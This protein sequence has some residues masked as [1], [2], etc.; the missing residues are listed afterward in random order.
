MSYASG[1]DHRVMV[2]DDQRNTIYDDAIRKAVDAKSVV[3][4]LGA[5][6]GIHGLLAAKVGARKV[7]LVEPAVD[8][9]IAAKVADQN[10]LTERIVCIEGT[11]EKSD[12][13]EAANIIISVFTGNFLLEEDLLPSLFY[14]R[15]KYLSE[16]GT[17]IPDRARMEVVPVT[18]A[19]YYDKVINCWSR[20]TQAINFDLLRKFAANTIY[21]ED[22]QSMVDGFLA[23]PA[24]ML[25]MDFMT[26]SEASCSEKLRVK[27]SKDGLCHGWLGWFQIR[28]GDS[29]LSTSPQEPRTHWSQAFLPL[30]PPLPVKAGE[31]MSFELKRPEFGEW[32]WTVETADVRQ[33]HSTFLS[34]PVSLKTL[35]KKSG[36]FN[37]RL[38]PEG[39][40]ASKV[41]SMFDGN[42]STSRISAEIAKSHPELFP[43][44]EYARRFVIKLVERFC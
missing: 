25:E 38:N 33:R 30:D 3:I 1:V 9:D 40:L 6:V 21:Y 28:L 20:P 23:E 31:I 7:Y 18:A 11:I 14:A 43:D 24:E 17:L 5:G 16:G 4:D 36:N 15:D 26:E 22:H 39:E 29:W 44:H 2:F 32:T 42:K 35:E 13:P 12:I 8:L 41:L 19:G 34:N 27:I 10:S 37:A